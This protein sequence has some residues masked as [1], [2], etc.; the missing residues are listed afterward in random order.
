MKHDLFINNVEALLDEK[1]M[2]E[3]VAALIYISRSYKQRLQQEDNREY[4]GWE[5][6]ELALSAVINDVEG[7]EE[8][9]ELLGDFQ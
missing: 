3:I 7:P 4:I 6:W 8:L 1:S 5:N 2:P 9:N